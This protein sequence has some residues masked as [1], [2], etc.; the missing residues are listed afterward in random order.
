MNFR[1]KVEWICLFKNNTASSAKPI[2]L[3]IPLPAGA[4]VCFAA[5]YGTIIINQYT[6]AMKIVNS[7]SD[8]VTFPSPIALTIGN[9]DGMH[10]GHRA[11]VEKAR[12]KAGKKG[13]VAVLTFKKHPCSFFNPEALSDFLADI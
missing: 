12:K 13:T 1:Q 9:F 4:A 10:V 3:Q 5:P 11:L 8:C 7:L 6:Y 2:D